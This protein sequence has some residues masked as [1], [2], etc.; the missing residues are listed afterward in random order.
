LVQ[1]TNVVAR[2]GIEQAQASLSAVS[3]EVGVVPGAGA[4]KRPAL[5]QSDVLSDQP[6]AVTSG[7]DALRVMQARPRPGREVVTLDI[8]VEVDCE[9]HR[10]SRAYVDPPPAQRAIET[11]KASAPV[12]LGRSRWWR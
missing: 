11:W 1:D 3:V 5:R 4:L 12:K 10:V 2:V 6:L 7:V 9:I 8:A